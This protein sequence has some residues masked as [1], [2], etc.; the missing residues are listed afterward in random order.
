MKSCKNC[1]KDANGKGIGHVKFCLMQSQ[2]QAPPSEQ[3]IQNQFILDIARGLD[4]A[5]DIREHDVNL[6][7][8][9]D[10]EICLILTDEE[11]CKETIK[12]MKS[13]NQLRSSD[14]D[15]TNDERH[16]IIV[17]NMKTNHELNN[18][19]S[20]DDF[21]VTCKDSDV[22]DTRSRHYSQN[23]GGV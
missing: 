6:V 15:A 4:D 19:E 9:V 8:P 22:E 11:F 3:I 20:A 2:P 5:D 14:L 23:R 16:N 21:N 12:R 7:Y 13:N 10:R 17:A 18:Y 1:L